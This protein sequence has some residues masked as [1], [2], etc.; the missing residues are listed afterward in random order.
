MA[1]R[2]KLRRFDALQVQEA[3]GD[4]EILFWTTRESLDFKGSCRADVISAMLDEIRHH[5]WISVQRRLV[6]GFSCRSLEIVSMI[7]S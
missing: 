1:Q 3:F 5:G 4:S 2:E 6:W 7:S